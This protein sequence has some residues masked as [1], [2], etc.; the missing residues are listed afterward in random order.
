[1]LYP[2]VQLTLSE[3]LSDW[4]QVASVGLRV[5]PE[6][7]IKLAFNNLRDTAQYHDICVFIDKLLADQI[8]AMGVEG[9]EKKL[10]S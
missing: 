9:G 7:L 5:S 10:K 4:L 3:W 8:K 6:A 1:M 2:P